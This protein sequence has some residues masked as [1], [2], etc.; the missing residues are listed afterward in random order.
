MFSRLT[1]HCL[2]AADM[3]SLFEPCIHPPDFDTGG[4]GSFRAWA[5]VAAH[6]PS[7]REVGLILEIVKNQCCLTG[8][9]LNNRGRFSFE[10]EICDFAPQDIVLYEF[11]RRS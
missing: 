3:G 2:M 9:L 1:S 11:V 6:G 4:N 7:R 5:A 10:V 8:C